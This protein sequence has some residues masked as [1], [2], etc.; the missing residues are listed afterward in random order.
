MIV[1]YTVVAPDW[2]PFQVVS[3]THKRLPPKRY[4]Y[5]FLLVDNGMYSFVQRNERPNIDTWIARLRRFVYDLERTR[6]PNEII[7]VLP[8]W[9]RDP[10]F[11]LSV[12]RKYSRILC[13]D[14]KCMV[15]AH[16][17]MKYSISDV[18]MEALSIEGIEKIGIPCKLY[19]SRKGKNR[20]VP[21]YACMKTLIEIAYSV[22]RNRHRLHALGLGFNEK[23][24]SSI[25]DKILSFDN[26]TWS[27]PFSA[28]PKKYSAKTKKEREEYFKAVLR[29][30]SEYLYI[31]SF[32]PQDVFVE[33]LQGV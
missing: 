12:T 31:P 4:S 33:I 28:I 11:T 22:V 20:R 5:Y 32:I 16:Y 29:K 2:W 8:D 13:K 17:N 21:R 24:L 18:I 3:I 1:F 23:L 9:L 26:T 25:R 19:C 14:Y 10:E 30:Y 15:V 27:R 6:R 7:V